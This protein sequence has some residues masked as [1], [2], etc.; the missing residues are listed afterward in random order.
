[1][2]EDDSLIQLEITTEPP[3][4]VSYEDE[5]AAA[6]AVDGEHSQH[7]SH[8]EPPLSSDDV[9][10]NRDTPPPT[11]DGVAEEGVSEGM[12][13]GDGTGAAEQTAEQ[14]TSQNIP[15]V[16][17]GHTPPPQDIQEPPIADIAKLDTQA[18]SGEAELSVE[19]VAG[20]TEEKTEDQVPQIDED[21]SPLAVPADDP[22]TTSMDGI[23][24]IPVDHSVAKDMV[25]EASG[26]ALWF[27]PDAQNVADYQAEMAAAAEAPPPAEEAPTPEPA[28]EEVEVNRCRRLD[29]HQLITFRWKQ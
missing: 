22:M 15:V 9:K 13:G 3:L 8:S 29:T 12:V 20:A 5:A 7:H 6:A 11:N 24:E 10:I 14:P 21:Q 1:M 4:D 26:D 2:T 28:V 27:S 17:F 18:A 19:E 23:E 25:K 16:I